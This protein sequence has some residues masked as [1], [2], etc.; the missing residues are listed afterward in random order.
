MFFAIC[1]TYLSLILNFFKFY[2]RTER[3]F[4]LVEEINNQVGKKVKLVMDAKLL[5]I[6]LALT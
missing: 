4:S 6:T 2:L 5:R 3:N 1:F